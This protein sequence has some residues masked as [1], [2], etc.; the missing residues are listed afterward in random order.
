MLTC[1]PQSLCNWNFRILGAPSGEAG[2]TFNFFTEQGTI[3][4]GGAE[5]TVRKHGWLSGEWSLERG[6]ETYADARKPSA[7][8]RSFELHCGDTELTVKAR[9]PF[10]RGFDL[11]AG[12]GVVGTIQPVHP[13]TRRATIECGDAVPELAQL[14][15]FWLVVLTWR[16][17]AKNNNNK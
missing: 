14:F 12:G 13:F 3:S 7:M 5:L 15:A 1:L 16:R 11:V 2:L 6:G 17:A 9:S 8:F 10:G 4:L